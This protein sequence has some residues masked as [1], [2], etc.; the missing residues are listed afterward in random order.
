MDRR[1]ASQSGET[2]SKHLWLV[3]HGESINNVI[4]DR[5][6]AIPGISSFEANLNFRLERDP[7]PG[8][9]ELG[10]TQVE[11][12]HRHP[13]LETLFASKEPILLYSSPLKR[14]IGTAAAIQ[15]I[16]PEGTHMHLKALLAEGGGL[17]K[18]CPK[19]YTN[20]AM[21]GN[22][23][24]DFEA[25]YPH[26]DLDLTEISQEGWWAN[27]VG[28]E[29]DAGPESAFWVRAAEVARW[30]RALQLPEGV[31]NLLVVGHGALFDHV[32]CEL[33][34]LDR[35]S[36]QVSH[37]NT[38]VTHIEFDNGLTRIHTIDSPPATTVSSSTVSTY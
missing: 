34:G 28:K 3:R 38:G 23:P 26:L 17:Y 18:T 15:K 6:Y 5:V 19:D 4:M 36:F 16:L 9:S 27:K 25:T 1:H 7:D 32:L 29:E 35:T 21:P 13:A 33:L 12:L 31:R 22:T 14:T 11:A 24:A 2:V 8:L 37:V 20:T 10:H 30:L